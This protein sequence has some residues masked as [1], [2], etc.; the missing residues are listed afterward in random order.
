MI[1]V[2]ISLLGFTLAT[3]GIFLLF[4]RESMVGDALAHAAFPGIAVTFLLLETKSVFLLLLGGNITSIIALC[5]LFF[6]SAKTRLKKETILGVLLSVF[7]GTGLLFVTIIQKKNVAHQ[8]VVN[9]LLFG[10]AATLL[11]HE[12]CMIMVICFIVLFLLFLFKRWLICATFDPLFTK[13]NG[14][15][16]RAYEFFLFALI[17]PLIALGL[18]VA[19]VVLTSSMLIAP[20]AAARQWTNNTLLCIIGAGFFGM[21]AACLGTLFSMYFNYAPTGPLIVMF[22]SFFVIFSLIF[23]PKRGIL[24]K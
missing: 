8:A 23:A 7:F 16:L 24:W 12:S 15:S 6:F 11:F 9:K 1:F 2:S 17:I 20:G 22:L 21:T 10:N 19:G 3:V 5:L 14:Y 4:R 18:Q 13:S